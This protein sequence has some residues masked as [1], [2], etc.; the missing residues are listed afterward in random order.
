VSPTTPHIDASWRDAL[1]TELASPA[2]RDLHELLDAERAA[3]HVVYPPQD[4]IFAAFDHTP[5]DRVRVVIVGQ[6]PYHGSGQAMGLAFGVPRGVP[7]PPSLR[8]VFAEL[9]DD[10]GVARPAHGDLTAWADRGVLLLNTSLTVRAN[11]AGSHS[12][13]GWEQLTD[14]AIQ[15]LAKRR[16]GIAFLLWGRHAQAKLP[17]LDPDRHLVLTAAHPSPLS[18]SK[19]FFG[20]RHF[21][22][23]NE[24]L[25]SRGGEP[26]DWS[27]PD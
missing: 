5:V 11:E 9:V 4:R 27:L 25:A 17:M 15:V 18:A 2:M 10:L 16:D 13:R 24:Y 20:C 8:N 26:V 23:V 21:S 3:G 12:G 22:R 6:D 14:A 19:G 1:A 7:V